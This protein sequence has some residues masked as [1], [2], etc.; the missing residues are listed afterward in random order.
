MEPLLPRHRAAAPLDV[1]GKRLRCE[2]DSSRQIA[3]MLQWTAIDRL[4]STKKWNHA[5]IDELIISPRFRKSGIGRWLVSRWCD[6]LEKL[7]SSEDRLVELDD[8]EMVAFSHSPIARSKV[9]SDGNVD[10]FVT[11]C[12]DAENGGAREFYKKLGFTELS[13]S[14]EQCPDRIQ[15]FTPFKQL[16]NRAKNSNWNVPPQLALMQRARGSYTLLELEELTKKTRQG[17]QRWHSFGIEDLKNARAKNDPAAI[18]SKM[19]ADF[20]REEFKTF[21]QNAVDYHNAK[22]HPFENQSAVNDDVVDLF[23]FDRFLLR[24]P[25]RVVMTEEEW[26]LARNS[27]NPKRHHLWSATSFMVQYVK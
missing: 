5:H 12:V 27:E 24:E 9:S 11:L 6:A 13:E 10:A 15:C 14:F 8:R 1:L 22:L 16:S 17:R 21:I 18:I 19:I 3:G 4:P 23:A 25:T 7:E 2:H 26:G 20:Y